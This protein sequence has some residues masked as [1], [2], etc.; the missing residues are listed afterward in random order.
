MSVL[1]YL[2]QLST[3]I[4]IDDYERN[5]IDISINALHRK[6]NIHF[7]N[8]EIKFVFGSY[9]RKTILKRSKDPNSDV[10]FLVC[11]QD[12]NSFK[13]QTL[14]T[15]LKNFA[16]DNYSRSEI[17]QSSPTVVLELNHIKFELVPSYS[18]WGTYYIPAPASN[19][20][21]WIATYPNRAK[22]ELNSK[23]RQENYLIRKTV[24]LIKYWNVLNGKVYP[25]YEL[26]QIV[27]QGNYF[28]C[29]SLKDYFFHVANTL[30]TYNLSYSKSQKVEKLKKIISD[31][32]SYE[33]SGMSVLAEFE[34]GKAFR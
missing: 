30:P 14:L 24:R 21:D 28:F 15:R 12:G 26:E 25:S 33:S 2:T 13:P 34:I 19:Y 9:D 1:T 32:K 3:D 18:S 31:T 23:N 17:Y 29:M 6:L 4:T 22:E 7:S 16:N 20:M 5:R 10:D 8:I 27:C 11:F